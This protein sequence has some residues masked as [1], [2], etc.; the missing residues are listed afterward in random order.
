MVRLGLSR[1]FLALRLNR[2]SS[3]VI[4]RLEEFKRSFIQGLEF[5]IRGLGNL[6][7][8]LSARFQIFF[9]VIVQVTRIFT[10]KNKLYFQHLNM[11]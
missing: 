7:H 10:C 9:Q 8:S 2:F 6:F 11:H 3:F 1:L 4:K 5:A